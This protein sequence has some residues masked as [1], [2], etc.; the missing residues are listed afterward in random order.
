[1]QSKYFYSVSEMM[2]V[3]MLRKHVLEFNFPNKCKLASF[4]RNSFEYSVND[5]MVF[6]WSV[7]MNLIKWIIQR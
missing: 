6:M 1:M 5:I 7:K 4:R 3:D 2:D